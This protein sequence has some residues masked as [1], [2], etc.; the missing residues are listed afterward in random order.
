MPNPVRD[1]IDL[2]R[3]EMDVEDDIAIANYRLGSDV[4]TIT[5]TEVPTQYS[6]RGF[7]SA[8]VRGVLD[9]ARERGLKVVPRCP[10]VSAFIARH[11]DYKDLL[12]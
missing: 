4:M 10:F 2:H 5:H 6:G 11:P 8:L 7:G 1:N 12:A 3:F 9:V